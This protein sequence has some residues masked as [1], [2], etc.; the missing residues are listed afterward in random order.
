MKNLKNYGVQVLDT[1]EIREIGGGWFWPVIAGAAV[2]EII[3]DWNNF[4][5]GLMGRPY[6]K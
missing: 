6:E 3:S 4:E 5:N 1:K 2:Y